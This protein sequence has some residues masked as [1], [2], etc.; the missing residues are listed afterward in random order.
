MYVLERNSEINY[1]NV[2]TRWVL[3]QSP[4]IK[5]YIVISGAIVA[6]GGQDTHTPP[7]IHI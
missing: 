6:G 1:S 3:S 7:P 2:K 4:P 5:Q